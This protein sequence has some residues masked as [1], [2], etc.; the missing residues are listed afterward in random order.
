MAHLTGD[1]AHLTHEENIQ[2][3]AAGQLYHC[4]TPELT[5]ARYRCK[6]ACEKFNDLRDPS[7]RDKVRLWRTYVV[8][9]LSSPLLSSAAY[10]GSHPPQATC[11]RAADV[12]E[13]RTT[14]APCRPFWRMRRPT[15][16]S[17]IIQT[18]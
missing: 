8:A 10:R 18:R 16:T 14:T 11:I 7:R 15:R 1:L 4:F 3:M 12:V 9:P 17:S 2:R 13:S 5:Q 6:K